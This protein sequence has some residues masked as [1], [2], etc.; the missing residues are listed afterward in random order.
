MLNCK[1][2]NKRPYSLNIFEILENML[3]TGV[4]VHDTSTDIFHVLTTHSKGANYNILTG[5]S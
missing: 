4:R 1:K 5:T 2:Q 3:N